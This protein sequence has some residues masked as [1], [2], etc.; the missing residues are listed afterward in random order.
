[1]E[2]L[3][4]RLRGRRTDDEEAVKRRLE[5]VAA[6]LRAVHEFDYAVVNDELEAAVAAVCEIVRA[7]RC[8][9]T[10]SVEERFGTPTTVALLSDRLDFGA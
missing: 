8:G 5:R 4:R 3:G 7:E 9:D 10:A 2:E 1:M 6:E